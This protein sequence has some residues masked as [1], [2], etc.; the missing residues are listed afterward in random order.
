MSQ[1]RY[2]LT[3]PSRSLDE[4]QVL[5]DLIDE[6]IAI[7]AMAV[8]VNETDEAQ[9]L[10]NTVAYFED[11]ESANQAVRVLNIVGGEIAE[12]PDEDWVRR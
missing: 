10:W 8:T 6:H 7:D 2:T 12:V 3:C 1:A 5:A 11:A 4:A 9:A